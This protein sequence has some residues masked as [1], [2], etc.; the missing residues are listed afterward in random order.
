M[1]KGRRERK[2]KSSSIKAVSTRAGNTCET[3]EWPVGNNGESNSRVTEARIREIRVRA[4][5][6]RASTARKERVD[7]PFQSQKRAGS[8]ESNATGTIVIIQE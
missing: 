2:R 7:K 3:Q 1:Q 8:K 4:I 5:R 6:E